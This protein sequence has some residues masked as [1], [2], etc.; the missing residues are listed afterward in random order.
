MHFCR[1]YYGENDYS[2][3]TPDMIN[4]KFI[5]T[6]FPTYEELVSNEKDYNYYN[7]VYHN[8][9]IWIDGL[10]LNN[11]TI[12]PTNKHLLFSNLQNNIK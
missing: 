4:L 6:K 1:K 8:E 7:N 12:D 9:I 10:V 5:S 2:K 3:V 11:A